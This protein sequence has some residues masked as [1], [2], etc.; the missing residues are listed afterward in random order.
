MIISFF[1]EFPTKNNLDKLNL[2][3]RPTKLYLAAKSL[4]EF[5]KIKSKINNKNIT[6]F[7][8]WPILEIREGYW[9]SPF[10][11]RSA[12]KR[13]FQ[14]LK[15]QKTP[16]MLDLEL[17]TTKNPKLYFTQFLNFPRNK[18]LIKKFI[19]NYQG[20]V[21]ASEYYPKREKLFQFLGLHYSNT[22]VIKMVYHS[23]HKFDE[24]FIKQ[25]LKSLNLVAYG[26]IAKGIDKNEPILAPKQLKKDLQL[27]REAKIKEVV[28]YRL[29]GLNKK[30]LKIIDEN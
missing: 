5:N 14:Q 25:K 12:L 23:M 22:K 26:T 3:K 9:I 7:I 2:I 6:E 29:G 18:S 28:I 15:N 21:Y 30:Y 11:K 10:T 27:A 1:E 17:P 16:V 13:I 4:N 24:E 8:Y 19:K 20:K